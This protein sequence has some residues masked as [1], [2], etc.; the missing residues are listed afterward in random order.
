MKRRYGL[1]FFNPYARSFSEQSKFDDTVVEKDYR[2]LDPF[3]SDLQDLPVPKA[4]D[5]HYFETRYQITRSLTI[6]RAYIDVWRNL[7]YNLD[8]V[9]IQGE[10]EYRPVFPLRFRIKQ[11]WQVKQLPKA[12]LA[13]TSRT[14]ET[15]LRIFALVAGD[16]LSLEARYGRVGLT[17]NE[18]YN[19]N[20]LMEGNYLDAAWEHNFS[21]FF[22]VVG[23]VAIWDATSMSQWIFEDAGIDFLYGEGKK[24]Y[25]TFKDRLSENVSLRFK[26]RRKSSSYPHTGIYG[27]G[28]E[29]HYGDDVPV[30]IRDF[31]DID[32]Q[33]S[34]NLQIDVRW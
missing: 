11:K 21:D 33:M 4:E 25:I 10:L 2:L 1:D 29:Y 17:P 26:I 14:Q 15:T 32:D 34:Y 9:R 22:S 23:G 28:N 30:L 31:T 13:T 27:S 8:N 20:L 19:G 6:T 16:Y 5:G 18:Q 12:V 7:A 24:Y 3:Y